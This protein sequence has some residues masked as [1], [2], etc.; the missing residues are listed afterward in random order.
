LDRDETTAVTMFEVDGDGGACET[1]PTA[2]CGR[3]PGA[4]RRDPA[5]PEGASAAFEL[6]LAHVLLRA[7]YRRGWPHSARGMAGSSTA[8]AALLH[9][10]TDVPD[11]KDIACAGTREARGSAGVDVEDVVFP[12]TNG[13]DPLEPGVGTDVRGW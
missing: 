13:S 3:E 1:A 6:T 9:D 4:I 2:A 12:P 10:T 5:P 11:M 7:A 8:R